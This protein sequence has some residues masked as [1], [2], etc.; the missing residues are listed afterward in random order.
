MFGHHLAQRFNRTLRRFVESDSGMTLPML[1]VSFMAMTGFAGAAV[2]VARMQ[3]VQS[4][5]S[6]ALD[7]AGLAAGSTMNTTTASSEVT[8]YMGANFPAGYL[9]AAAPS[10]SVTESSD[11]LTLDL[12]AT[13][14]VPTTF[15]QVFGVP[16]FTVTATSQ[17][18]RT[19]M[20]LEL[21][22]VLDNTGSMA[23][24]NK[25]P[26]L[27]S[28]ATSLINILYGNKTN[29]R[30]LWIGL[31]PFSQSVNI[32]TG[33]M[34]WLDSTYDAT[35]D[36]G[37][38]SWA[39]CVEPREA[40]GKDITDDPPSVQKFK[41]Y[42]YPSTGISSFVGSNGTTY[43]TPSGVLNVNKWKTVTTNNGVTTTNY[44]G[45]YN[46]TS[47]GPN[48]YCPLQVV[49]MTSNKTTLLNAINAM[50]PLGD[51]L[52]PMGLSWGWRMLSPRWRG[53]WGGEMDTNSLPLDYGTAHMNK[54][55][56]LLTDGV[57]TIDNSDHGAYGYLL[58]GRTGTTNSSTAVTKLDNKALSVCTALKNKGVYVYTISLGTGTT[59]SVKTML[60]NCASAPNYYFDSPSSTQLQAI[61][62]AIGDSLSNL[63][64]SR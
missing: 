64:V 17:I 7:A 33:H 56:V 13:T 21:A 20:G 42:Y 28:A 49:P 2:D 6:F 36:W 35:L 50:Q 15:M 10:T 38:T 62:N 30:N 32:G 52:I 23:Q 8:K 43:T 16:N 31:V 37:P 63:R 1:A 44:I 11:N 18:A 25:L 39:G 57:N 34:D 26:A 51:T 3:L 40:N 4:R 5:L 9:G 48:Y 41:Q 19:V 61:F 45:P 12:S 14:T 60:K 24:D 53:L 47:H 55:V 46:T 59:T 54:A 27:K 29:V 22:L 58:E